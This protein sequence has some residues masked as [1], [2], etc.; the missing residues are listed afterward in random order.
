MGPGEHSIDCSCCTGSRVRRYLRSKVPFL[1]WMKTYDLKCLQGD[2]IA[3]L[4]VGMMVIPQ[5]LAYAHL[6]ELPPNYG[7]YASF[8][9]V[10]VYILTGTCKDITIGPTA[11]MS[12][13]VAEVAKG[14]AKLA[15]CCSL[16]SG[17][18]QM[19]MGFFFLGF[20]VWVISTPILC[21]FTTAAA[22]TIGFTQLPKL[23][24]IKGARRQFW[25]N[26]YDTFKSI[27]STRWQDAVLGL[28][29]LVCLFSLRYLQK[30]AE[31]R[32]NRAANSNG[33]QND[34][35]R[36]ALTA[37]WFIGVSRNIIV[38]V[39]ATIAA[40][41][42]AINMSD[43][44]AHPFTMVGNIT[45]GLPKPRVDQFS[46][47]FNDDPKY[48]LEEVP[49]EKRWTC[50][51]DANATA[52]HCHELGCCWDG[53]GT[54][55]CFSKGF[56]ASEVISGSILVASIGYLE[57]IAI[58]QSF[59]V[60][61]SYQIDNSQ[62][63]IALGLANVV[64]SFFSSYPV[65]GSFS[66]TALNY[67]TGV[68][69]PLVGL[70][71]SGIVMLGLSFLSTY[72]EYVPDACL[73]AV[74]MVAV[75]PMVDFAKPIYLWKVSK[76]EFFVW[77]VC[78][79]L[80]LAFNIEVGIGA[81]IMVEIFLLLGSNMW[82]SVKIEHLNDGIYNFVIDGSLWYLGAFTIKE[83]LTCMINGTFIKDNPKF[84]HP[85][86][87]IIIDFTTVSKADSTALDK[88]KESVVLGTKKDI[89]IVGYGMSDTL[90]LSAAKQGLVHVLTLEK[91]QA[92]AAQSV[93]YITDESAAP[94]YRKFDDN[95]ITPA[96]VE[97][98]VNN[99]GEYR[100]LSHAG[101]T[102]NSLDDNVGDV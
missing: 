9:G 51:T 8:V 41:C 12:Q 69:T 15:L 6:A 70:F 52:S 30:W 13:I 16:I 56:T 80:I 78:F 58:G 42:I 54:T 89:R 85:V 31:A 93:L 50:M 102:P 64:G 96:L 37:A 74:I 29:C 81:A 65:T 55:K 47:M 97:P 77:S 61:G 95:V 46:N 39:I 59:A 11:I 82:P 43:P 4:T 71:T 34:R 7:L 45:G 27:K 92:D 20:V 21:G 98:E 5:G 17:L 24:G 40:F 2:I 101:S 87:N 26:I 49:E 33:Q 18:L 76:K 36:H 68:K 66:R 10:L 94:A 22:L 25:Q 73:A 19:V 72:F 63:L 60:K 14:N 32:R 86:R 48:C 90:K 38:V 3:G 67:M 79:V 1:A 100:R 88:I 99:G 23:L 62:E 57:H 53:D 83:K 28:I 75:Y 35:K 91:N 84:T 44:D